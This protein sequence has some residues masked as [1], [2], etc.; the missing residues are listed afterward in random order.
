MVLSAPQIKSMVSECSK[1]ILTE[2]NLN[3]ATVRVYRNGADLVGEAVASSSQLWVPITNGVVLAQGQ[4]ITA[5]QTLGP[6]TSPATPEPTE[7]QATPAMPPAPIFKTHLYGCAS[8]LWLGG[9]VP[10]AKYRVIGQNEATGADEERA[11]GT[12][13]GGSSHVGLNQSLRAGEKLRADED[14]CGAVSS[15][16][17]A[18]PAET[19]PHP[20]LPTPSV[21]TPLYQ[22]DKNVLASDG[23]PGATMW[24]RREKNAFLVEE[25]T[26]CSLGGANFSVSPI[27]DAGEEVWVWQSFSGPKPGDGNEDGGR[28]RDC[29]TRSDDSERA[30]VQSASLVE[31]P[32]LLEPL[33]AGGTAV[34]LNNLR[35][36]AVVVITH[37]GV[38]HFGQATGTGS[39]DFSVSPLQGGKTVQARMALCGGVET[40]TSNV[41]T[42]DPQPVSIPVP[43]L[44]D[45]L[46]ACT[47]VVHVSNIHPG[48]LVRVYSKSI[49]LI[50]AAYVYHDEAD[51]TVTPAL[52]AGDEIYAAQ[53][54]CGL[55]D[56]TSNVVVV[57]EPS[58]LPDPQIVEPLYDCGKH[59]HVTDVV[60]GAIVEVYVNGNFAGGATIS[61]D[62][63]TVTVNVMLEKEDQVRARQRLCNLVSSFGPTVTVQ[64]FIGEWEEKQWYDTNGSPIGASD[65]ILAVHATLLRTGKVLFFG[66]DQHTNSLN[67]SGNV[68]HTRLMDVSTFRIQKVTGLVN[69]PSDI[70]CAGHA[71]TRGGDL[72]V[73]GGTEAWRLE[74]EHI[75]HAAASHFVGSRDTWL[76]DATAEAW[77]RKGLLNTERP[78]DFVTEHL[79]SWQNQNAGAT[80][81][82]VQA[83]TALLQAQ[84]DANDPNA[85]IHDTGGKW[86]P[87]VTALP[88]GRLLCV[89]GHPREQDSRHNNDSLETYDLS[90]GAWTLVGGKDADLVPRTVGRSYEYPRLFVLSDGTVF[91][92]TRMQGGN[93]HKWAIGNDPDAWTQVAG[94]MD[95]PDPHSRLN[96]SAVL[97]P[98]R[99][100]S[101][102]SY[103]PDRVLIVGGRQPQ[104]ISPTSP[105]PSWEN[106][107]S[108]QLNSANPPLRRNLGA[109]ILP[110]G[111]IF[112]EGGVQVEND[113]GTGIRAAELYDSDN[114][115]W[116]VLPEAKVVRNYHH[117]AL[118]LPN[119]SVYV[120]GSNVDAASGLGARRFEIEI[121]KPWYFCRS[122]PRLEDSPGSAS[123]GSSFNVTSP[124][125]ERITR[126]V[127]VKCGTTTHNFDSDQR[128]VELPVR[129][130]SKPGELAVDVPDEKNILVI[131]Y[132]LL[133]IL[134][135]QNVPSLGRFIQIRP[136]STCFIATA[137]YGADARE[138]DVLRRV[139]DRLERSWH[140][141]LLVR[142]Y[143]STSPSLARLLRGRPW[144]QRPVRALLDRLVSRLD[145]QERTDAGTRIEV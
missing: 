130:G 33:C 22:C 117:V 13:S 129:A 3:G 108:R 145:P 52:M 74:G 93:V 78:A 96:G 77:V 8:C 113:D 47:D 119:G 105:N 121:F 6:D 50:G 38:E 67:Q 15:F 112:I 49:G 106:T 25:R 12:T 90:A 126:A 9:M 123:H 92:A 39:Q 2:G 135:R 54:G 68:D 11:S 111:E 60:P 128:L 23:V 87:T 55:A 103:R 136:K 58:E 134:D 18:L 99:L 144:L 140:G 75:D 132:Y 110:T 63:G 5:T 66:G 107:A 1:H 82:E 21:D 114:D 36:G 46:F 64:P 133:F 56:V 57:K 73:A 102:K 41:V 42:V 4:L 81:E 94:A 127:I 79:V 124:D 7:V 131:G 24:M 95:E 143:E 137:I 28:Q 37:D 51:I 142:S 34:T 32:H 138:T 80:P 71:Q 91:S 19:Y 89:S 27:L 115:A 30:I 59:V 70:F 118:L 125:A 97:L 86:Y 141:R 29:A 31:P 48:A 122:R 116:S 17:E 10:G 98:F 76:F 85:L 69:P 100:E 45:P 104:I 72:L 26:Q 109:V 62:S 139:R 40:D 83:Q 44:Q 20:K 88:D 84:A 101:G 53:K 43:L 14:A 65:K 16:A 120:G 35:P 61:A